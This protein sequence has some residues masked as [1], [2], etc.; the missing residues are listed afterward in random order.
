MQLTK[1]IVSM[2]NKQK[3]LNPLGKSFGKRCGSNAVMWKKTIC[4]R[5]LSWKVSLLITFSNS[6]HQHILM[7]FLKYQYEDESPSDGL[8]CAIV[9]ILLFPMYDRDP[10]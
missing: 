2:A 5:M 4:G 3:S 1:L 7:C 10:W 9:L 8:G 6:G